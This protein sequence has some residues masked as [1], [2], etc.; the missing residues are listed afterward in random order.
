MSAGT[1]P[2]YLPLREAAAWAGVSD[3]TV[4]RWIR[5]GLCFR[6]VVN[7]GKILIHPTDIDRFLVPKQ[8]PQVD[9]NRLV[10]E[11]MRDLGR[12]RRTH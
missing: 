4:R 2:G 3:K 5:R 10:N 6:Q 7:G 8:V 12:P 9:L 1:M 11:V